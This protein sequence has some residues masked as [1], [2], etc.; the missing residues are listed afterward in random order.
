MA[1]FATT[2]NFFLSYHF[3]ASVHVEFL[4]TPGVHHLM[5]AGLAACASQGGEAHA[6]LSPAVKEMQV[7][8][9]VM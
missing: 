3:V 9:L 8:S 1:I 5:V 2:V 6:L 7:L 4:P